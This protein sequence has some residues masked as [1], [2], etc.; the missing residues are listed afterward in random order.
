MD[1]EQVYTV[2]SHQELA[3]EV[4]VETSETPAK[5]PRV[6]C[7]PRNHP[8]AAV[9]TYTTYTARGGMYKT[10]KESC[11]FLLRRLNRI[12]SVLQTDEDYN[13][14]STKLVDAI[15]GS[16]FSIPKDKMAFVYEKEAVPY[17]CPKRFRKYKPKVGLPSGF[18]YFWTIILNNTCNVM[19]FISIF[20]IVL[21]ACLLPL[22]LH[23][24]SSGKIKN[25]T[26]QIEGTCRQVSSGV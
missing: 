16:K 2:I 13:K 1:T 15:V 19:S 12:Y 7:Q 10:P 26:N 20:C 3:G 6:K 18:R 5:K 14:L 17:R 21:Y 23:R 9:S 8:S 4:L 11:G 22:V 24:F 25:A